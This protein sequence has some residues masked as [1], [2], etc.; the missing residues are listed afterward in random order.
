MAAK[1]KG[2]KKG[3][4]KKKYVPPPSYP[5]S[6]L[7]DHNESADKVI[8]LEKAPK[9]EIGKKDLCT[10]KIYY[11]HPN[12]SYL[13][14][15]SLETRP[16][17][18]VKT[19]ETEENIQM[20]FLIDGK[21]AELWAVDPNDPTPP[22]VYNDDDKK[23]EETPKG[24]PEYIF[25]VK[26]GVDGTMTIQ[27]PTGKYFSLRLMNEFVF[28]P[29]VFDVSIDGEQIG[30]RYMCDATSMIDIK[31]YDID[32]MEEQ[33]RLKR[34]AIQKAEEEAARAEQEAIEKER[35]EAEKAEQ[36]GEQT[37][38]E[39][40]N[41]QKIPSA[42]HPSTDIA[43][44]T[45]GRKRL[46]VSEIDTTTKDFGKAEEV[47]EEEEEEEEEENRMKD[48]EEE[49]M[50]FLEEEEEKRINMENNKTSQIIQ[51]KRTYE[52]QIIETKTK[53]TKTNKRR[54][55]KNKCN[56]KKGMS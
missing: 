36:E 47:V 50:N 15:K 40:E 49:Q 45:S 21:P 25:V 51:A 38:T 29:I 2:K 30:P 9:P 17:E 34:E 33:E 27:N 20:E 35:A 7:R 52:P 41:T 16:I 46:L 32:Y 14:P 11:M 3:G 26:A 28:S 54:K 23:E 31:G 56:A 48:E 10:I 24:P 4:R 13:L 53:T 42:E 18:T 6:I 1:K 22:P 44:S 37:E 43:P 55:E 5:V 19:L 39:E 8:T 12:T